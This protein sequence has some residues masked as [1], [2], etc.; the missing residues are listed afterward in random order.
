MKLL[1]STSFII[2]VQL[3]QFVVHKSTIGGEKFDFY[4]IRHLQKSMLNFVTCVESYLMGDLDGVYPF[5]FDVIR[6]FKPLF[7]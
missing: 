5:V 7:S 6:K 1:L 3:A 2:V 4:L